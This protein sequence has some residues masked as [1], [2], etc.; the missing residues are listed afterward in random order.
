MFA[1]RGEEEAL[2]RQ[3][4]V[5]MSLQAHMGVMEMERTIYC[6]LRNVAG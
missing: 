1:V 6:D 4:T 5:H 2:R 3:A